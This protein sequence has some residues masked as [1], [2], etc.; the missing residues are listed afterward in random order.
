MP[1]ILLICDPASERG[2]VALK[3]LVDIGL[4]PEVI[5]AVFPP[6]TPPWSPRYDELRRVAAYGY[7]MIRGEVGC[8]LAHRDAWRRVTEGPD[9]LVLVLEDDAVLAA[10]DLDAI[11]TVAARRELDDIVTLLFTVSHMSFRRWRQ[12]GA[13]SIVRPTGTTHST[14]AYLIGKE[15]AAH[16]LAHSETFFCPVDDYLNMSYLH[17]VT[18][19]L[20][21]PFLAGYC[22]ISP[23]L[24]GLRTKPKLTNLQRL[25]R[26]G[27]RLIRRLRASLHE[28]STLFK[29]GILFSQTERR[30]ALRPKDGHEV[31]GSGIN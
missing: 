26:N 23:S 28:L 25:R 11:S 31:A 22:S 3:R 21:C 29:M 16:L 20:T 17:G 30:D 6:V 7:P 12:V 13:V 27:F 10:C 15:S 1:K 5:P 24:I 19:V 14:V 8:F 9:D 2:M 18:L 4:A